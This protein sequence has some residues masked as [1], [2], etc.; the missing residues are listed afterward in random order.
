MNHNGSLERAIRM[1]DDAIRMG[2]DCAKFQMRCLEKVYRKRSLERTGD[3]L[4]AEY[5]LDLL[6]RF[7]LTP[8]QHR[9]LKAYCDDRGIVYM[10]TPWDSESADFLDGMGVSAFKVSS[11]DLTK[12]PLIEH[13]SSKAKPLILSTGMS[14][15]AEIEKIVELL[16]KSRASFALLHCNSTYPAPLHDVHLR[17]I[18]ELQAIHPIVGYSGHE[19]GISVSLAAVALGAQIIE[20]HYTMDRGMEGPDHA[21]SLDFDDFAALI[22]GIREVEVALGPRAEKSLS[23]GVMMN[24]ENLGKSLVAAQDLKAGCILVRENV[25][26]RSPGQGLSPLRMDE[27]LGKVLKRDMDA[28]D[29]FYESDLETS[30]VHPRSYSF[31]RPWGIPVRYH[32]FQK[33]AALVTPDLWEFHLSY[34][35]L[36]LNPDEF[37]V[38]TY[39]QEFVVHAPELF[40]GSHLMDLASPDN[41]YRFESIQQTQRVVNLTRQLKQFFPKT[42]RPLIVANIGGISMDQNF[43]DA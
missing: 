20:R 41:A 4:N 10:C 35:D 33:Y 34:K 19:R 22:R 3:D 37:L 2:A 6:R 30:L 8:D 39:A 16:N 1:V 7:E 27:L 17:Y 38:G 21:A 29:F 36:E 9:E 43:P 15:R 31:H 28:E 11:A 5:T 25:S 14:N 42:N 24:R 32:D 18:S 26:V 23:Q 12:L 40:A 13:L